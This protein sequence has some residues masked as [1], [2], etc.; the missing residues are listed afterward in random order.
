[1]QGVWARKEEEEEGRKAWKTERGGCTSVVKRRICFEDGANSKIYVKKKR[2]RMRISL[3][4][5]W[6]M[7]IMFVSDDPAVSVADEVSLLVIVGDD[8]WQYHDNV[9]DPTQSLPQRVE[10]VARQMLHRGT[11]SVTCG[12]KCRW[13]R[14][15]CARRWCGR[16][17]V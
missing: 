1:M 11:L 3:L 6:L 12:T 13:L 5:L 2:M 8:C 17:W 7:M 4:S 9:L 16:R 14:V 15:V 10:V